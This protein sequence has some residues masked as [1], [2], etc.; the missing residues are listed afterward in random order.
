MKCIT[1][2]FKKCLVAGFSLVSLAGILGPANAEAATRLERWMDKELIPHLT[3]RLGEHPRLKGEAF[4]IVAM[5]GDNT[6]PE[7]DGLS[8][9]LREEIHEELQSAPGV[10]LVWRP[11]V[12]PWKHPRSLADLNCSASRGVN[13][14]I[15][16]DTRWDD[17]AN[18][19]KVS[20]RALDLEEGAWISGFGERYEGR[21]SKRE[22]NAMAGAR[23]DEHLRGLK[24][25]PFSSTQA[26][27]LAS[28]LAQNLSCLLRQVDSDQLRVFAPVPAGEMPRLFATTMG[29]VDNYLGQFREVT[30]TADPLDADVVLQTELFKIDSA[31]GIHQIWVDVKQQNDGSTLSGSQTQAYLQLTAED[32][33]D[34]VQVEPV[35][36]SASGA[37]A[38]TSWDK[39]E[40]LIQAA[41]AVTVASRS[42]CRSNTPW[43]LGQVELAPTDSLPSGS[44]FALKI[45]LA[46]DANL[47]VFGQNA[48]G[49]M[50]RLFPSQC[51]ALGDLGSGFF[52][53]GQ[54]LHLPQNNNGLL[55]LD[56][57]TGTERYHIVAVDDETAAAAVNKRTSG[58][59]DVCSGGASDRETVKGFE[60]AM[61][62]LS[63][64]TRGHVQ[65]RTVQFGHH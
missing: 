35:S 6:S 33:A 49:Q 21:A 55:V 63:K 53:A 38:T 30:L 11:T 42:L 48:D 29:I 39:T 61:A 7:I 64:T 60:T 45:T 54:Q 17:V 22:R 1:Q 62:R 40:D 47:L 20:V 59:P 57:T 46:Q 5:Q 10:N 31:R 9:W 4:S 13:V 25:L 24:P 14:Q 8:E 12:A 56:N 3:E 27:L 2:Q 36:I 28:Y 18:K 37:A 15:G 26:D 16:I 44:C 19:L 51:D 52:M 41:S 58:I 43:M 23:L 50:T 65:H 32:L 34:T